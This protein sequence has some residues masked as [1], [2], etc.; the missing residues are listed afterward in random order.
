VT[1]TLP[2]RI[3]LG[4]DI[5]DFTGFKESQIKHMVKH[6][7]FPKPVRLGQRKLGW[8]LTEVIAWQEAKICERD[9]PG[10]QPCAMPWLV[11][12]A[13]QPQAAPTTTTARWKPST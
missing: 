1:P 13:K 8:I 11:P 7:N 2:H 6:G 9:S 5:F 3:I 12:K 4:R 10:G